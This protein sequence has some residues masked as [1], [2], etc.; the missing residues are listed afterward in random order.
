ME[1]LQEEDSRNLLVASWRLYQLK[2]KYSEERE[3]N[4][5]RGLAM[6]PLEDVVFE[7][8]STRIAQS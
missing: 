4:E 3:M 5:E 1:M 7:Q 8:I 2:V 6:C